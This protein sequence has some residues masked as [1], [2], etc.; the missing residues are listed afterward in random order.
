MVRQAYIFT[1]YEAQRGV[2]K[3]AIKTGRDFGFAIR[4]IKNAIGIAI[5]AQRIVTQIATNKVL[6]VTLK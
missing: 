1:K 2:I 3:S 6:I 5:T 4:A